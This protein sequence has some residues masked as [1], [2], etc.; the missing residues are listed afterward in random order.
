MAPMAV[1]SADLMQKFD[2]PVADTAAWNRAV[3][4][5]Q[6]IK[7]NMDRV[8]GIPS[9]DPGPVAR[10]RYLIEHM[11]DGIGT[12]MRTLKETGLAANTMVIFTSDNGGQLNVAAR[13]EPLRDGKQSLEGATNRR[14]PNPADWQ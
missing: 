11:D 10:K 9:L 3:W 1:V 8:K 13:N 5:A 14:L 2:V 7:H 4:W 6:H 12:V